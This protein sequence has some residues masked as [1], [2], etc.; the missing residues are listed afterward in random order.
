[1]MGPK[2]VAQSALFY[3]FS[4]EAHISADHLLRSID[5]FVDTRQVNTTKARENVSEEQIQILQWGFLSKDSN[6]LRWAYHY[7]AP[8]SIDG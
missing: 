4:L 8:G 6:G 1:M 3:E 2:Q 5:R 7:G